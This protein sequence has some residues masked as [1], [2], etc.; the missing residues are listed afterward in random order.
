MRRPLLTDNS[1]EFHNC[2][3]YRKHANLTGALSHDIDYCYQIR[4]IFIT[5]ITFITVM[6]VLANLPRNRN[7]Y[8][9]GNCYQFLTN[10]TSK[11]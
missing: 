7:C 1:C 5:V 10:F 11:Y 8:V 9:I 3:E 6:N 2:Y 4:T